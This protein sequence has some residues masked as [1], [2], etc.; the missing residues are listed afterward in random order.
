MFNSIDEIRAAAEWSYNDF[1]SPT[2]MRFSKRVYPIAHGAL[3][4]AS[5]RFPD[6]NPPRRYTIYR[7][8]EA[9]G[10]DDFFIEIYSERPHQF[11]TLA[12][13]HMAAKRY[14]SFWQPN[15]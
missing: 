13:A 7:A 11:H 9:D 1:F 14:A 3:F 4:I 10:Y 12:E 8:W 5:D 2:D 6:F 15:N